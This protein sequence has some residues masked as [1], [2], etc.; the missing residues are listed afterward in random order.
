MMR[1]M[2]VTFACPRCHAASRVVVEDDAREIRCAEC[3]HELAVPAGAIA[4]GRLNRCLICPSQELFV[5]K[6][7]SQKLGIGIILIGFV[8]SSV[9]WA[10]YRPVATFAI[11][12][13]TAL[14]DL[15]L[16]LVVGN[17][18]ECYR[19]QSLYREVDGLEAHEPFRLE[20]HERFRQQVARRSQTSSAATAIAAAGTSPE[21]QLTDEGD[22]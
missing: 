10:Y 20:T 5:R 15:V 2:N 4:Q 9:T 18:L 8:A 1:G 11:L 16:Y 7:F 12:L 13:S 21:E 19:C 22:A 14:L 17:V 3:G 6:D